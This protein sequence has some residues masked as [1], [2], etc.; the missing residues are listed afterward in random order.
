MRV[1]IA[2]ILDLWQF[3]R[4]SI[5]GAK[6]ERAAVR[7]EPTKLLPPVP[8]PLLLREELSALQKAT[9]LTPHTD[10]TTHTFTGARQYIAVEGAALHTEPVVAFDNVRSRLPYGTP[11]SVSK[12]SG[13]WA[14][15]TTSNGVV[16]WILGEELE[17]A[18][19]IFPQFSLGKTYD[20]LNPETIKLRRCIEDQ[21]QAGAC[22]LPLGGA[23]YVT[24]RLWHTHYALPWPTPCGR[25]LGTWHRKLRGVRGVHLDVMPRTGSIM[26]YIVDEVGYV[27]FIESVTPDLRI[28]ISAFGLTFEGQ[29]SEQTMTHEDWR[30][31][32]PVFIGVV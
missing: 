4:E 7:V 27:A 16:G 24:Y 11:V 5:F 6:K 17:E 13:R 30:E 19:S 23:E 2:V 12:R 26:E 32:H 21:F 29:Y 10:A 22:T 28:K 15:V 8:V 18:T 20:A 9:I 25:V 14:H 1:L 3:C 31:L